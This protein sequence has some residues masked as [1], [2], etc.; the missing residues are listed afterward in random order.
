MFSV[1]N[2]ICK[3]GEASPAKA[4]QVKK[5]EAV[6]LNNGLGNNVT[7]HFVD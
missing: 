3:G 4:L 6:H 1:Q 7:F 5:G 2:V